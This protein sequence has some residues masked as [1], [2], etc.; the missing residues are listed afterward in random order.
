M[1][2][3]AI[4]LGVLSPSPGT[5]Q[6]RAGDPTSFPFDLPIGPLNEALT[7]FA[8]ITGRTVTRDAE[9][10]RGVA[11]AWQVRGDFTAQEALERILVGTGYGFTLTGSNGVSI[12]PQ[13]VALSGL[14]VVVDPNRGYKTGM[15]RTATKTETV[16]RDIPQSLSVITGDL[17]ADQKMASLADL[18]RYVPGVTMGQ[19]EGNRDQPT[20]RG[21]SGNGDLFV[22]GV[23]DD[24]E[25]LRD[26]YNAERVEVP[27]GSNAMT[28][29]R[30]GGGGLIN[31]VTKQATR[32]PAQSL[33]VQVGMHDNKRAI[34]DL[35][36]AVTNDLAARVMGMYEN[37]DSYRHGFNLERFGVTPT[38][39][40]ALGSRTMVRGTYEYFGDH[41][42]ADRGIPSFNGAPFI[43]ERSTFFGDPTSS[44][45]DIDVNAVN[46]TVERQLGSSVKVRSHTRFAD[47]RKMYQNVFPGAVNAAGTQVSISAYNSRTWRTNLFNQT[48]ITGAARTGFLKHVW[49]VGAELGRQTSDAFRN[50]GYFNN[51][52][53]SVN[54]PVG[55]P[56]T[57]GTPVTW[58][59][60]ATDADAH[61]TAIAQS[62]YVQDQIELTP[63]ILAVAGIRVDN[64][65]LDY[66][67]NRTG[68]DLSR[69]DQ[70]WSPRLGLVLKPLTRLSVYG[71]YSVSFLPS[72]GAQFTSLT[73]TTQTLEPEEF[74]NYE[75]G[76]KWDP[77]PELS[78]TA[79]A[80]QLDRSNTSAPDPL[81]PTH[82]VQTGA[83]RSKGL[84]LSAAGQI[85]PAWQVLFGYNHQDVQI[86][87]RTSAA[88]PGQIPAL[89]P[90]STVSIWNKYD[91]TSR[92]SL[93]VGLLHQGDM[94]AAIDNLVTLP[95]F[96]RAD[97]ALVVRVNERVR[98]QVNLE[99]VLDTRYF[100]TAHS[101]NNI[102]PG[103]PR[104]LTAG[105]TLEY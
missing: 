41:R 28:F 10:M 82:T 61:T 43:T 16:L 7:A 85:T 54:V 57:V 96:T 72:S 18:V 35:G 98:A 56:S 66:H 49:L 42:T 14:R 80:Y 78:L 27:K 30:A 12:E 50:T 90:A 31:R 86:T 34:V 67:N 47:Y 55:A 73:V 45:S 87:S 11:T 38:A 92:V 48:D 13:V 15:S 52:A 25:Y 84:E 74:K 76:V 19:G 40:L 23:R 20:I 60:S 22:D 94:F 71:S 51:T 21:N 100:A 36:S 4:L 58:R 9:E 17:I 81:D 3:L 32:A 79:A 24:T 83:Q 2:L 97:A 101:N 99:N 1:L 8:S 88:E 59:Q 89:V 64:F 63:R 104:T 65:D 29:G 62:G 77:T 105:V 5:A 69:T 33:M 46:G 39:T 103:A 26:L 95:G 93:G 75:V 91:V 44:W 102:T 6:Q 68:A 37:S 53:M 70:M